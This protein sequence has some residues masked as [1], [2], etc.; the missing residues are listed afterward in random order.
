M[1]TCFIRYIVDPDKLDEFEEY[2]RTWIELVE[3]YGGIH[4][5]YFLPGSISD[6]LPNSS[7]SFPGIG[8]I[9][10]DNIAVALFSFPSLK[11]YEVYKR[12][13]AKD[14]K[15]KA[16]MARSNKT[17]C[18]PSYERNFLKPIFSKKQKDFKC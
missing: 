3:K 9:G 7:F 14:E 8:K 13:V 16:I 5:G 18:F 1:F 11:K 17:K 2:A 15:C 6:Q 12:E 4:H 10:P